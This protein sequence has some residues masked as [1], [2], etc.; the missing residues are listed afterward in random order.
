MSSTDKHPALVKMDAEIYHLQGMLEVKSDELSAISAE[1][2]ATRNARSIIFEALQ[3]GEAKR[4]PAPVKPEKDKP[5]KGKSPDG[6]TPSR[7]KGTPPAKDT[8]C[9]L[10]WEIGGKTISFGLDEALLVRA[11]I[12][13]EDDTHAPIVSQEALMEVAGF[14]SPPTFFSVMRGLRNKLHVMGTGHTIE[15][16]RG[17]G[18]R[19]VQET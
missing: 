13:G 9:P 5:A 15:N 19:L 11:L 6:N 14:R 12:G 1:L 17:E 4:L 3:A 8:S 7:A 2:S 18:Y 16:I 10:D